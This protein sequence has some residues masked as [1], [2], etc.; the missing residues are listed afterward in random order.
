V[1][2]LTNRT[3]KRFEQKKSLY[4]WQEEKLKG[5]IFILRTEFGSKS[6]MRHVYRCPNSFPSEISVQWY[7][8]VGGSLILFLNSKAVVTITRR[9]N[10]G[11]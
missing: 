9:V 5:N 10:E 3:R 2:T 7:G 6:H 1:S 11:C 8:E 4:L